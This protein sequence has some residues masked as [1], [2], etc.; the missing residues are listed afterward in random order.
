MFRVI[1]LTPL[2]VLSHCIYKTCKTKSKFFFSSY[3]D[4]LHTFS[5]FGHLFLGILNK[6]FPHKGYF[7]EENRGLAL[8]D[9][10]AAT[11]SHLSSILESS[12]IVILEI[13]LLYIQG[14]FWMVSFTRGALSLG[15]YLR[16]NLSSS[17]KNFLVL[18]MVFS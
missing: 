9:A 1:M 15:I 17:T 4:K 18:S 2:G 3:W 10:S 8:F 16:K 7:M 5:T 12:T 14:F 11:L 6:Y 13:R